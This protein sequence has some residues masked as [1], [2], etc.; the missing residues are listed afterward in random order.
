MITPFSGNGGTYGF[1]SLLTGYLYCFCACSAE[2]EK[3]KEQEY[4]ERRKRKEKRVSCY[5]TKQ[6]LQIMKILDS[7]GT[8]E[9]DRA[10][11]PDD[12]VKEEKGKIVLSRGTVLKLTNLP[13]GIDRDVIRQA[14][15]TYPA[16]IAHVEITPDSTAFVRLRGEN[17]GKLVREQFL[18]IYE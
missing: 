10:N 13:S 16:D 9:N 8:E 4:E 17:D 7:K 2:W 12:K 1:R 5:E 14:F 18:I 3:E 11:Q 15:S 6:V